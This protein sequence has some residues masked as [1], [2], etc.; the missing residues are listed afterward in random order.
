[1]N[2]SQ[3]WNL[4]GYVQKESFFQSRLKS[5]GIQKTKYMER[6]QKNIIGSRK[7]SLYTNIFMSLYLLL[8]AVLPIISLVHL[9]RTT[10]N[11]TNIYTELFSNSFIFGIYFLFN[12]IYYF[13][14]GFLPMMEFL[15]GKT[16]RYLRTLPLTSKDIQRI[17]IFT[18]IRM[19]GI[20]I[21]VI[22]F[23]VPIAILFLTKNVVLVIIFFILNLINASF[24]LYLF[25]IISNFLSLNVFNN[26]N[27]SKFHSIMRVLV[28]I[29]YILAFFAIQFFF[30]L[31]PTMAQ[32]SFLEKFNGSNSIL[33]INLLLSFILFPLTSGYIASIVFLPLNLIS[34]TLI[35][36]SLIAFVLFLLINFYLLRKGNRILSNLVYEETSDNI[37]QKRTYIEPEKVKIK[38]SGPKIAYIKRI[39]IMASREQGKLTMIILPIIVSVF[40][41]FS[42]GQSSTRS[43]T[44]PFIGM[45]FYISFIPYILN[46]ALSESEEGLGGLLTI[47]PMKN[48]DIFRSKQ[49][50]ISAISFI[51]LLVYTA[52]ISYDK[53]NLYAYSDSIIKI[54]F[55]AIFEPAVYLLL[56][57]ICFGKINSKYTSFKVNTDNSLIKYVILV[58]SQ[59]LITG[60]IF[61]IPAIN[62]VYFIGLNILFLIVLE[63]IIRIFIK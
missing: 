14:I 52:V 30:Q 17:T 45:F 24:M 39:F 47:L 48:R 49:Y 35:E 29:I 3:L 12:I 32:N 56:F 28:S 37:V 26:P 27:G 62:L 2:N 60:I 61:I 42:M 9:S 40:F 43:F 11:P 25:L 57:S 23:P 10:I 41:A 44:N 16:F 22:L 19:N 21:L 46:N 58:G 6:Y 18:V 4:S 31:I 5:I 36:S 55:L 51:I 54:I 33:E 15:Q 8:F 1:M 50:I 7:S 63:I 59:F 53:A 38:V 13:L 34:I 20:Q